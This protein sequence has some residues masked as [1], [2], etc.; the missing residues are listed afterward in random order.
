MNLKDIAQMT[1][2][3][4]RAEKAEADREKLIEALEMLLNEEELK[5]L[6]CYS[7]A[8]AEK[9]RAILAEVKEKE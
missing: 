5:M 3:E 8:S 4:E 1:K 9:A 2:L 6:G 7:V